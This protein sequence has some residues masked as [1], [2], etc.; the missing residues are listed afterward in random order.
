M[1]DIESHGGVLWAPSGPP[2]LPLAGN[3][4]SRV[5]N[6]RMTVVFQHRRY[7]EEYEVRARRRDIYN[8]GE[9]LFGLPHQQSARVL[10]VLAEGGL[11][12]ARIQCV[13]SFSAVRFRAPFNGETAD[14]WGCSADSAESKWTC[15]V[16]MCLPLF[17]VRCLCGR[18]VPGFGFDQEG[19]WVPEPAV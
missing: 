15:S 1:I 2:L 12:G 6:E 5:T 17:A 7:K 10:D 9:D 4:G 3:Q 19:A 13:W 14:Q 16:G 8:L 11:T 18:E